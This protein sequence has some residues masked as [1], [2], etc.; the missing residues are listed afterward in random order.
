MKNTKYLLISVLFGIAL[1]AAACG[2]K[3]EPTPT[4]DT[5]AVMTQVA[6]T[7]QAEVTQNALLT[8][9]PTMPLPPTATLPPIPTQSAPPAPTTG[10]PGLAPTLPAESPDNATAARG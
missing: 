2:P 5:N 7:V 4:V 3:A 10:A 1:I 6:M 9:S 8:P